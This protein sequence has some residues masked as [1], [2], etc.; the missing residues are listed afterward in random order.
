M[1]RA[2][3][4]AALYGT[5]AA[6]DA[7]WLQ[8]AQ[9][10]AADMATAFLEA[11]VGAPAGSDKF[12]RSG[13]V[14]VVPILGVIRPGAVEFGYETSP[15]SVAAAVTAAVADED[16]DAVFMLVNSPGGSTAGLIEASEEIRAAREAGKPIVAYVQYTAASAAY[17]LAAQAS[18]IVATPSAQVGSIG[19]FAMHMDRSKQLEQ[20][21]VK[22]EF[23][24][25]G[26]NKVLGNPAEP[27]SK[28]ARAAIQ[29]SV[30]EAY[31]DFIADV[32]A[33]R[34]VSED[35]ARGPEFG[36]GSMFGAR[37]ALTRG[38]VDNVASIVQ[39]IARVIGA[40]GPTARAPSMANRRREL[41]L[42]KL[43]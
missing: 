5:P 18:E 39:T 14:A 25:A 32:A 37:E 42:I 29:A 31:A 33:G 2:D 12:I 40:P 8:S 28:D 21:G 43:Q 30:D 19:V 38:L 6:I 41:A 23:I 27:L 20:D 7:D 17:W 1:K 15:R 35:T 9:L 13:S 26:K 10:P 4:I 24:H 16:V 11:R 22:V 36:E 3:L 34:G